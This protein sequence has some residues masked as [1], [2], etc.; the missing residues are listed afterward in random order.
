MSEISYPQTRRLPLVEPRFGAQVADPYRWLEGD[1]HGDPEVAAWISAQNALTESHLKDLPGREIFRRRMTELLDYTRF[2]IPVKRGGRYFFTRH[3]RGANQPTLYLREGRNGD[4]DRLLIDPNLWSEDN[5]DALAEWAVSDD[6]RFLAFAVQSGGMD[7]RRI[8]VLDVDSGVETRDL[9]DWSKFTRL[10]WAPDGSGFFYSRL[11]QPE[12]GEER[13]AEVAAHAVYFHKLG[14]PQAED[15][16]ISATP[17]RPDLLHIADRA[18]GGRYLTIYSTPGTNESSLTVVDLAS[19]DWT[20]RVVI[21]DWEAEWSVVGAEGSRLVFATTKGAERRSLVSLD[22]S[23]AAPQ[24]VVIVPEAADGAVLN[25]A[26]L[27][28]GKLLVGYLVDARTEIRRFGLDGAP[29]GAVVLP[30]LGTAGGLSGHPH[31][32]EAF[33]IFTSYNAPTTVYRYDVASGALTPWAKP[34]VGIDLDKIGVEQRFYASKDGTRIP[35]FLIRRKDLA[36][37]APTL[38]YGYG[39]FGVSQIPAYNSLQLSWVEQGGVLAVANIRGGG[40]Y[41]QAWHRDGKLE[42]K[43]NVFDDFVAAAEFLKA[44]GIAAPEGLAV[45][46]ESPYHNVRPGARYPAVLVTTA[47]ADDRVVPAHSFKYVAA[48]Q[49]EDLGPRP[50]L[51]RIETRAGHGAGKPLDKIVA[52]H[53]DM[54][55]FAARWTGLRPKPVE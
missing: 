14:T 31:D 24:P 44:E 3:E 32:E 45:Q 11:P 2:T 39:G 27:L 51:I 10:A 54:W 1:A 4:E 50:R 17:D 41:G 15:R 9:V 36:G 38:L 52:Q 26:A 7:W 8:K 20:P 37:P 42:K 49:A 22:L 13:R 55:A 46:G 25:D 5:A 33:F 30:G 40:E 19:A 18:A 16:L 12:A 6:G 34:E 28:G 29:E 35:I 23:E 43:Q 47:D 53:A 48:L 21:A